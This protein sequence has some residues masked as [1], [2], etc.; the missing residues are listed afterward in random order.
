MNR[1]LPLLL[2]FAA[3]VIL[4]GQE[5]SEIKVSGYVFGDYYYKLSGDT[6]GTYTNKVSST[7]QYFTTPKTW[8]AFQIRR[9][10]VGF[11]YNINDDIATQ[12]NLEGNDKTFGPAPLNRQGIFVK[13]AFAEWKNVVPMSSIY[14]GL[15]P[16]PTWSGTTE[17]EWAY[18]S[19]EKTI[20]DFRGLGVA[21]DLGFGIKGKFDREGVASYHFVVGNGTGQTP[22]NDK[23][24]KCYG[25]ITFRP[26]KNFVV[27]LYTDYT[28]ASNSLLIATWKVMSAYTFLGTHVGIEYF[29]QHQGNARINQVTK[30]NYDKQ[31][32]GL[33]L[34]A[35]RPFTSK[36]NL[37]G[38]FD[39]FDPDTN[40]PSEGFKESFMSFGIDFMPD[41]RFHLIPNIWINSYKNKNRS[42]FNKDS[43][44][45]SRLTFH[46]L[47][48]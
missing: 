26:T 33:S 4:Y 13:T 16:T 1:Y 43:D 8:Q 12:L 21:T 48:K 37:A 45:V 17:K 32:T 20:T 6:T 5:R 47:F 24:K 11:D 36:I 27:D 31:T 15:I 23:Y 10:Y 22:E 34:F 28:D 44:V 41:P 46:F 19:I 38:R 14:I 18:R 30:L 29:Q 40:N 35:W 2:F 25:D 42:G 7:S 3:S 9:L 39:Y